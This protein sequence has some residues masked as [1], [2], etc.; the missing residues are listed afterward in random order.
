MG[1]SVLGHRKKLMQEISAL[2][3]RNEI[4]E[5][6]KTHSKSDKTDKT[7]N[8]SKSDKTDKSEK[9][10]DKDSDNSESGGS[11]KSINDPNLVRVKCSFEGEETPMLFKKTYT[12]RKMLTKIEEAFG[13]HG[14]SVSYNGMEIKDGKSKFQFFFFFPLFLF[15]NFFEWKTI[16]KRLGSYHSR[17][18]RDRS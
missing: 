5:S 6:E 4:S 14:F 3:P 13:I 8:S 16:K 2:V 7:D 15:K 12:R 9:S 17:K 18:R 11:S 1:V 10:T